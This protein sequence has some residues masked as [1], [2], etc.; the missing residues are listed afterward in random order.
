MK[1]IAHRSE[2]DSSRLT[3]LREVVNAVIVKCREKAISIGCDAPTHQEQ[4]C[5]FGVAVFARIRDLGAACDRVP[6]RPLCCGC[7]DSVDVLGV[8]NHVYFTNTEPYLLSSHEI[9]H[10]FP[11]V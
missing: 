7:E 4:G 6:W 5:R 3:E 8:L 10:V 1:Q 9:K 11:C 2:K